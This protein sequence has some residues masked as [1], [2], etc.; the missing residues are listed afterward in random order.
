M[1]IV[2]HLSYG[3]N[4]NNKRIEDVTLIGFG[5]N[6][7]DFTSTTVKTV[8]ENIL[9]TVM[10]N[11][12]APPPYDKYDLEKSSRQQNGKSVNGYVNAAFHHV[13]LVE[14]NCSCCVDRNRK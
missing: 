10:A 6:A 13:E 9:S 4:G 8:D 5:Q 1:P 7:D 2:N 14:N 11:G 12:R 3:M